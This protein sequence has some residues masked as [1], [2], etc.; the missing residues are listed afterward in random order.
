MRRHVA[1]EGLGGP[2]GPDPGPHLW[3]GPKVRPVLRLPSESSVHSLGLIHPPDPP[4]FG[5]TAA[6]QGFRRRPTPQE[7]PLRS[8]LPHRKGPTLPP[9]PCS[10]HPSPSTRSLLALE[11]QPLPQ[12]L[13]KP[14]EKTRS[15]SRLTVQA[16]TGPWTWVPKTRLRRGGEPGVQIRPGF[17]SGRRVRPSAGEA[18]RL[19][20]G[21][22]T[23]TPRGVWGGERVPAPPDAPASPPPRERRL[24]DRRGERLTPF[25]APDPPAEP[26]PGRS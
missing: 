22:A 16:G 11:D 14:L 23:G 9:R 24:S 19:G 25:G 2:L 5:R 26:P 7:S 6:H 4:V 8:S 10:L 1:S 12:P 17:V 15:L 21:G 13:E 20:P 3:E 18:P